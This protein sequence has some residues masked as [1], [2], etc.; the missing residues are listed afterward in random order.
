MGPKVFF[1]GLWEDYIAIA[2]TAAALKA[3]LEARG[4]RIV[5][6]H[7]AFRTF[8]LEP[9]RLERLEKPL[10]AMGYSRFEAYSFE[11]KRLRAWGY[12]HPDRYPRIFLSE[13]E[14]EKFSSEF[15][16]LVAG[17][18]AQVP[19]SL[20]DGPSAFRAGRIW[21]PIEYDTWLTLREESEYAAW[22]AALG[23]RANHFTISVNALRTFAD[24]A[25]LLDFIESEGFNLNVAGG[26]IKGDPS[27]L[28]EQASTLADRVPVRFAGG[29]THHVPTCYVE[30]A[31]RYP[32][33]DGK[34]YQGFVAASAD[35]IFESTDSS[36]APE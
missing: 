12:I 33:P 29:E 26:R 30:F 21:S 20:V 1:D 16:D 24:L 13:L 35:R 6:D 36:G 31:R 17:L 10:L 9:V 8:N 19:L 3:R 14:T 23:L 11:Q 18:C 4:E 5:N 34:I 32:R 28:L 15:Q 7:I 25:S 22:L 2:P 27:L